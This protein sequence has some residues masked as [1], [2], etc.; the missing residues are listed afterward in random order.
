MQKYWSKKSKIFGAKNR[1]KKQKYWCK[2]ARILVNCW[3]NVGVKNIPLTMYICIYVA[4]TLIDNSKL[5][6]RTSFEF[7]ILIA[8]LI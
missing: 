4:L 6:M 8:R 1:I 3:Q 5:A 7:E 2:K